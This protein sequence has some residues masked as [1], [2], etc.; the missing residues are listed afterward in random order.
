MTRILIIDDNVHMCS[1]L[2]TLVNKLGYEATSTR[3]IK[4]GIHEAESNNY[5]VVLLDVDLPDGNGLDALPVIKN[6]SSSPE[7]IIMTGFGDVSGAEIAIKNGAWDYIQKKHS[8]QEITLA[9]KRVIQYKNGLK[10]KHIKPLALRTK[11]IIGSSKHIS[12]CLDHLA[13]AASS[14]INVLITGETGTGKELFARAIHENSN[15]S[16]KNFVVVDC[17][18]LPET[19][20]ES[21]LFGHKKGTFTGAD[22]SR[23]GL[24][25]HAHG[26]TLFLDEIGDLSEP[27]QKTFLRVLQEH[28]YR[29]LG[30]NTESTSDF[31]LISATNRNLDTM[32]ESG[33]FRTDLLYRLRSLEIHL[34]P[35]RER[36]QDTRDLA[37]HY[38][39][40]ICGRY[41]VGTKGFSP[42]FFEAIS[43]YPWPGN[44][45]ELIHA[46]ERAISISRDEHTLFPLH[47]SKEIRTHHTCSSISAPP[48]GPD[49]FAANPPLP[50]KPFPTL[51][52]YVES[53]EKEYLSKLMAF[54][55][56]NIKEAC[57]ISGL[58]RTRFYERIKKYHLKSDSL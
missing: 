29:P 13:N 39:N 36:P 40:K 22:T 6:V 1:M 42:E 41:N 18:A 2:S 4:D 38:M 53:T 34:P 57:R 54:T 20:V 23:N 50:A 37:L 8:T 9:L 17:T 48:S 51:K 25:E 12:G 47:L 3:L 19:L 31:R 26:G 58:S 44:V 28:S 49:S 33:R 43:M 55:H 35:L 45:R 7:V 32:A 24:I 10:K 15:R 11:G 16:H 14:D 27:V 52:H 56:G 30:S 21:I 46:L 5:D